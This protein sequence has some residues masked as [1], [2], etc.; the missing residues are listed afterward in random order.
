MCSSNMLASTWSALS[1]WFTI[2]VR[3]VV[4]FGIRTEDDKLKSLS[5][6]DNVWADIITSLFSVHRRMVTITQLRPRLCSVN[7]RFGAHEMYLRF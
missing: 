1:S 5:I 2:L 7:I 3:D 4:R 6:S